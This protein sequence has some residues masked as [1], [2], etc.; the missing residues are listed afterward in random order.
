MS[1]TETHFLPILEAKEASTDSPR[2]R[3][4]PMKYFTE[5]ELFLFLQEAKRK[6]YHKRQAAKLD[7]LFSLMYY[8]GLRESEAVRI[9]LTDFRKSP[10]GPVLTIKGLKDGDEMDYPLPDPFPQKLK[11][12][13]KVRKTLHPGNPY[14]F[15]SERRHPLGPACVDVVK[16]NFNRICQKAGLSGRS[17]H[18]LRHT[19]AVHLVK[20]NHN[21]VRVQHWLRH[22]A[23]SSSQVYFSL[24]ED[25][26][27]KPAA[28]ATLSKNV[29]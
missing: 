15:P 11:A 2:K 10:L 5:D 29:R 6:K 13:L 23:L 1:K 22:K 3:I 19:C 26:K 14:L 24:V 9:R 12:W 27:F 16:D 17:P 8:L 7:L 21:A 25:D 4:G 28:M 20:D 18:S